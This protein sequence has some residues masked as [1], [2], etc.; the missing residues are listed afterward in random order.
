MSNAPGVLYFSSIGDATIH[1]VHDVCAACWKSS[2]LDSVN[3]AIVVPT[4]AMFKD[5]ISYVQEELGDSTVAVY[6][7]QS[8]RCSLTVLGPEEGA[9]V[10]IEC[11][12]ISSEAL[13]NRYSS[14]ELCSAV[15]HTTAS[16]AMRR[17]LQCRIWRSPSIMETKGKFFEYP[18][19][20]EVWP[21]CMKYDGDKNAHE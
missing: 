18:D 6:D 9:D 16:A 15:V 14:M 17:A 12:F 7:H 5:A 19:V 3:I 21:S 1:L 20:C 13:P 11:F 4:Y 8:P 2:H 10:S